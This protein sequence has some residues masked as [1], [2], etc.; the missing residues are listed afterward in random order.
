MLTA[1]GLEGAILD[2]LNWAGHTYENKTRI[3]D[4]SGL[5][6]P[7]IYKAASADWDPP[8]S[9]IVALAR[10]REILSHTD[11]PS[12]DAYHDETV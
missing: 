8:I 9:T 2:V 11:E 10:A 6:R 5:S 12:D 7:T 3:A 1:K 4:V